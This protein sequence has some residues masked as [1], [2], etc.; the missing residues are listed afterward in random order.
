MITYILY[1]IYF[2]YAQNDISSPMTRPGCVFS[3]FVFSWWLLSSSWSLGWWPWWAWWSWRWSRWSPWWPWWPRRSRPR[4]CYRPPPP[5]PKSLLPCLFVCLFDNKQTNKQTNRPVKG[6]SCSQAEHGAIVYRVILLHIAQ[7]YTLVFENFFTHSVLLREDVCLVTYS[8]FR[9]NKPV[10]WFFSCISSTEKPVD[11][12][13]NHHLLV[14]IP[15]LFTILVT[16]L[17]S[18]CEVTLVTAPVP[19][20]PRSLVL[21]HRP[22]IGS[23]P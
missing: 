17:G 20:N 15:W 19:A 8:Y 21:S 13:P 16:Q 9:L 14:L 6:R 12:C 18:Q 23:F 1:P 10:G 3:A 4:C 2:R 22:S 7:H 5:P 11:T